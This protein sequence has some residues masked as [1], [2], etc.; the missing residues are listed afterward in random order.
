MTT[1]GAV[2]IEN[3]TFAG[4]PMSAILIADDANSWYES[5]MVK[6]VVIRNNTFTNIGNAV[7]S[8]E[9][10][11]SLT[12]PDQT[13]HSHIMVDGNH[14]NQ[15]SGNTAIYAKSVDGFTFTNNTADQG[16]FELSLDASKAVTVTGNSF[17]QSNADKKSTSTG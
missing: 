3:N 10:S 4:M 15:A 8:V 14:F 9:P 17:T 1:R 13:V 12:N 2:R 16:G 5:G 11:T 6:D 7:I